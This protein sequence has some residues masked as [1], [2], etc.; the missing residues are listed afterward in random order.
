MV[1]AYDHRAASVVVKDEN[2]M[3][4]G[5]TAETLPVQHQNPEFTVNPR[6]WVEESK[7]AEVMQSRSRQYFLGACRDI[8]L[9]TL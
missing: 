3:R 1:Q 6:W 5:Q 2:W 8:R 9:G 7:V 4:Q